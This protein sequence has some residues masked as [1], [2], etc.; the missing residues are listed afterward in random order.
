MRATANFEGGTIY[1][2][3]LPSPQAVITD[4]WIR[5][6]KPIEEIDELA[7]HYFDSVDVKPSEVGE[8]AFDRALRQVRE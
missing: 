8:E 4:R 6:R 3:D 7:R 1:Q 2:P 5:F